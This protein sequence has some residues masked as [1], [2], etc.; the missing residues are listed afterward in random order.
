[1]YP[2]QTWNQQ[3][4]VSR[5]ITVTGNGEINA[6]PD[7]VQVQIEVRTEGQDVSLAQQENAFIMNRVIGSLVALNIPR[8]AIQTT[9][10]TIYPNYDYIDGKQVFRGYE[11]QNAITVKITDIS[12]AGTVID[13]AIQNGA[14]HVSSIQFKIEN[15]G[16]YYQTALNLALLNAIAKSKSMVETLQVPLQPIPIEITEESQH[17]TP[18]PYKSFQLSNQEFVTPIEQGSMTITA[19]VRVKFRF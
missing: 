14:N 8:E 3:F 1:M 19:S 10:Y 9:A 5:E 18:V 16:A 2:P 17:A 13:T 7:Y 11:V 12:Q 15:S 4:S 6:Q